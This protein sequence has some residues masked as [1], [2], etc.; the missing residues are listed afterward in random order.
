MQI[1]YLSN[2]NISP[3]AVTVL[4][5]REECEN[6]GWWA[7]NDI[8]P[9]APVPLPHS[10][11]DGLWLI[12]S[13]EIKHTSRYSTALELRAIQHL[14]AARKEHS[15][16]YS[17][18][19]FLLNDKVRAV[20]GIYEDDEGG[21]K[22]VPRK[23][24]KTLD[25]SIKVGDY[26]LVPTHTRHKMT[27]NK[28]V[29]V[30]VEP[31]LETSEQIDWIIGPLDDVISA[32]KIVLGEEARAIELMKAAEKRHQREEIKKKVLAHVDATELAALQITKRTDVDANEDEFDRVMREQPPTS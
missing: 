32:G 6:L 18:A 8:K 15:M 29:E 10:L 1:T 4:L 31:P 3:R 25:Q 12:E 20:F 2:P 19:I 21:K 23:L 30:D 16:N 7:M 13:F 11:L 24:F 14:P 27:V 28:I 17:T 26:V 5:D 22:T 9:D